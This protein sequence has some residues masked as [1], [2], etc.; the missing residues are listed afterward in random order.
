MTWA[1]EWK[2]RGACRGQGAVF[3]GPD[4]EQPPAKAKR[5]RA[6]KAVC[7]GCQVRAE[8]L[9]EA[10]ERDDRHGVWGGLGEDERRVMPRRALD[11][12]A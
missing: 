3:F 6:A 10:V 1:P 4:A 2:A 11:V 8:C 7:G 5:E 9:A 12:V